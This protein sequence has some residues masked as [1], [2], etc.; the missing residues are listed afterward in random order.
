MFLKCGPLRLIAASMLFNFFLVFLFYN[1]LGFN[2]QI[3]RYIYILRYGELSHHPSRSK[4][5]QP[6]RLQQ[7]PLYLNGIISKL[8]P[9]YCKQFKKA[10]FFTL[11]CLFSSQH[12]HCCWKTICPL[13]GSSD[14]FVLKPCLFYVNNQLNWNF[15]PV[16]QLLFSQDM[17]NF[18][19]GHRGNSLWCL[20]GLPW[21]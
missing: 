19:R 15:A 16:F 13:R 17:I 1:W 8:M 20:L 2:L 5:T 14:S 21:P 4:Y 18:L 6:A 3:I 12:V 11:L 10:I 7:S 9:Q